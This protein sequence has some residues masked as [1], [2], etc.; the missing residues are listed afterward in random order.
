[1]YQSKKYIQIK[2][3]KALIDLNT[4]LKCYNSIEHINNAKR[5]HL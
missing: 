5:T 3:T 1:M 2:R 4:N